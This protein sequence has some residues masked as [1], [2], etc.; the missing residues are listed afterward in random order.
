MARSDVQN[1]YNIIKDAFF[2]LGN[3]VKRK[4]YDQSLRTTVLATEA[5]EPSPLLSGGNIAVLM[6]GVLVTAGVYWHYAAEKIRVQALVERE[7]IGA[8]QHELEL[9][10]EQ[11]MERLRAEKERDRLDARV[12]AQ[13]RAELE[14]N[15]RYG[16]QIHRDVERSDRQAK[17][18]AQMETQQRERQAT[19]DRREAEMR[20]S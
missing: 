5:V 13:Q 16:D 9:H 14:R 17:I 7:K 12:T 3:P 8:Q 4:L 6:L 20:A 1:Q 19:A 2:T 11:E 15:R 10:A 18:E